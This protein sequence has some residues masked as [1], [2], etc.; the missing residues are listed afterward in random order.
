M[1]AKVA[2]FASS[3]PHGSRYLWVTHLLIG[4]VAAAV[5]L[6]ICLLLTGRPAS[7]QVL[8]ILGFHGIAMA[9]GLL[10]R[11]GVPHRPWMDVFLGH[12]S[13]PHLPGGN[14]GWLVLALLALAGYLLL[15][16]YWLGARHAEVE[17]GMAPGIGIGGM[18]VLRAQRDPAREDLAHRHHGARGTDRVLVLLHGLGTTS[19]CWAAVAIRLA[20]AGVPTVSV[21]LLGHGESRT[22]GTRF[23]LADQAR[24]LA[25]LLDRQGLGRVTLVGHSWGAAV[26]VAVARLY[27]DRVERLLLI[28]P[29]AFSNPGIARARLG[30]RS[31]F[32]RFAVADWPGAAQGLRPTGGSSRLPPCSFRSVPRS[33]ARPPPRIAVLSGCLGAVT[34]GGG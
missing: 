23:V 21:D 31:W 2:S 28:T 18:G 12:V 11:A 34:S 17:Q 13:A 33:L 9:P 8:T 26:A 30:G 19:A 20:A 3:A 16:T 14:T 4:L 32:S 6:S 5:S 29:P 25:R 15:L 1:A 7:G 10:L 22:L 27:P 24:A